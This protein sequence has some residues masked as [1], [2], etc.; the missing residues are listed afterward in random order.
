MCQLL[1]WLISKLRLKPEYC[2]HQSS[3][4]RVPVS[5][6]RSNLELLANSASYDQKGAVV[7]WFPSP[8]TPQV[9]LGGALCELTGLATLDG[10]TDVALSSS[11]KRTLTQELG[12]KR[13]FYENACG[14]SDK[15][16]A[17]DSLHIWIR[18]QP[19]LTNW[20]HRYTGLVDQESHYY[21]PNYHEGTVIDDRPDRERD[22]EEQLPHGYDSS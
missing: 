13:L 9:I 16:S 11:L 12:P 1:S 3:R 5:F 22:E 10:V 15:L 14:Y 20:F 4:N 2:V 6:L 8:W 17:A 21:W 7:S 19:R 18:N